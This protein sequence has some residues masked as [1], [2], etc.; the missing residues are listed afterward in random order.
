MGEFFIILFLYFQSEKVNR[1]S[2]KTEFE[3]RYC[4]RLCKSLFKC[5]KNQNFCDTN[6]CTSDGELKAHRVVLSSTSS[7]FRSIL[8]NENSDTHSG[9]Y[10]VNMTEFDSDLLDIGLCYMYTGELNLSADW[11]ET[12]RV[13]KQGLLFELFTTLGL[14]TDRLSSAGLNPNRYVKNHHHFNV[15]FLP[16]LIKGMDGCFPT[17]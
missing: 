6:I 5:Y 4:L 11:L 7:Y 16:R 13:R 10:L 12:N 3:R 17:A 15:H 1:K 8:S 2:S 9:M 14:S